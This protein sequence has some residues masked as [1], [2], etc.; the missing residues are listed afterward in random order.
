MVWYTTGM[1]SEREIQ[2]KID[3][4]FEEAGLSEDDRDLWRSRISLSGTWFGSMFVDVFSSETGMLRFF[5]GDL[6]KR[7]AA[8]DDQSKLDVVLAE[9][10]DYFA[11]LTQ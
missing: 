9:E 3:R 11:S 5:T 1:K 10:R 6:R 8:G 7:I 2:E 4:I